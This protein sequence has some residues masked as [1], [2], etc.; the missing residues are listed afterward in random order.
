MCDC[1]CACTARGALAGGEGIEG[2][3]PCRES[4][5][6]LERLCWPWLRDIEELRRAPEDDSDAADVLAPDIGRARP[7]C[8]ARVRA[9]S[10][11][12][13]SVSVVIMVLRSCSLRNSVSCR[14]AS[15]SLR[16][17]S[18]ESSESLPAEEES[19]WEDVGDR[20]RRGVRVRLGPRSVIVEE[21]EIFFVWRSDGAVCVVG[22]PASG[23]WTVSACTGDLT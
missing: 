4:T 19:A 5:L 11:T 9:G 22:R 1:R 12:S 3:D 14:S 23:L 6:A 2:I 18:S 10:A 16:V 17:C 8:F 13:P 7:L 15:S 21:E 20:R